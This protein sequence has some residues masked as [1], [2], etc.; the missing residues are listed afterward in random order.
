M[1]TGQIKKSRRSG[2]FTTIPNEVFE[3]RRLSLR[4]LGLLC[5]LLRL[6]PDWAIN[7]KHLHNNLTGGR[8]LINSA[9]K[10]LEDTGYIEKTKVRGSGGRFVGYNYEVSEVSESFHRDTEN[11]FMDAGSPETAEPSA[12]KSDTNNTYCTNTDFNKTTSPPGEVPGDLFGGN[13]S[14]RAKG[15]KESRAVEQLTDGRGLHPAVIAHYGAFFEDIAKVPAQINGGSGKGAKILIDYFRAAYEREQS[16]EWIYSTRL[17]QNDKIFNSIV[18]LLSKE[19]WEKLEN[20]HQKRLK[21]EEIA[22]N[23]P[24]ILNQIKNGTTKAGAKQTGGNV[25]QTAVAT[26]AAAFFSGTGR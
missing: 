17:G 21:L 10:E 26:E 16:A 5:W 25:S 20:F 8:D 19:S 24:N 2:N 9:F 22:G 13:P 6:P 1:N 23:L 14:A 7:K 18:H 15:K 11:P 3:D 12:G 4:A